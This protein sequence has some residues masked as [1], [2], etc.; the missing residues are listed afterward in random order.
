[1]IAWEY[2]KAIRIVVREDASHFDEMMIAHKW[3]C[4]ALA[5]E[6]GLTILYLLSEYGHLMYSLYGPS[7]FQP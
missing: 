6:V 3:F 5:T 7:L 2:A 4:F 1:M